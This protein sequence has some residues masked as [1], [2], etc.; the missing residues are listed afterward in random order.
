MLVIKRKP[1]MSKP[2]LPT[3]TKVL[4]GANPPIPREEFGRNTKIYLKRITKK[5]S[6]QIRGFK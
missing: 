6:S 3:I 2:V 5:H 1:M 4:I